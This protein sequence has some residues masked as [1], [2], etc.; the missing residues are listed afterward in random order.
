MLMMLLIV[1][2][3]YLFCFFHC[4]IMYFFKTISNIIMLMML[5]IGKNIEN[6]LYH[7]NAFES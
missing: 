3:S 4:S 5:F 1:E 2:K 7:G 6:V